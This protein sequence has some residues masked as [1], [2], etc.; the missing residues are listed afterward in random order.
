[1]TYNEVE[2]LVS[3]HNKVYEKGYSVLLENENIEVNRIYI[4]QYNDRRNGK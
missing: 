4:M 2:K 3:G 1:M